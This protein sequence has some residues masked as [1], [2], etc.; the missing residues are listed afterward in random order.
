MNPHPLAIDG[1]LEYNQR[2]W[3]LKPLKVTYSAEGK[4]IPAIDA[5]LYLNRRGQIR[6]PPLTPFLPVQIRNTPT[7]VKNHQYRQWI[8]CAKLM[9]ADWRKRGVPRLVGLPPEITDARPLQWAGFNVSV[10]YTFYLNFPFDMAQANSAARRNVLR[11]GETGYCCER[12]DSLDEAYACFEESV[13][14]QRFMQL[15][16]RGDIDVMHQLVGAENFRMYICYAPDGSPAC[17]RTMLHSLGHHAIDLLTGT[18]N[19]HMPA[20][21]TQLL[22]YHIIKDLQHAGATGIDF[23]GANIEGVA[24]SKM[25]WGAE[26]K[27]FFLIEL[28]SLRGVCRYLNDWVGS[29]TGS[30][31]WRKDSRAAR[32]TASTPDVGK[33]EN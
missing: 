29:A 24:S 12:T 15:F 7:G 19:E 32:T 2:K 25:K 6:M 14:R 33:D 18:R 5:V 13:K 31:W 16:T 26:L 4:A 3:G 9:A 21:A 28:P 22:L 1:W 30:K 17:A 8:T 23:E 10:R 11:A 20:G 27:P